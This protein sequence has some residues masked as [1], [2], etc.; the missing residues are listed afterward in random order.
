MCSPHILIEEVRNVKKGDMIL[1]DTDNWCERINSSVNFFKYLLIM[2]FLCDCSSNNRQI[3]L[4]C[5]YST[6]E[7]I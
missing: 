2:E 3:N 4:T 5:I 1:I 6:R 7:L